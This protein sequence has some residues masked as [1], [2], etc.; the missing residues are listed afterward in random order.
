MAIRVAHG[1]TG[2]LSGAAGFYVNR[3]RDQD[4]RGAAAGRLADSA[5]DR[6]LRRRVAEFNAMLALRDR[7]RQ[8]ERDA[9]NDARDVADRRR[10]GVLDAIGASQAQADDQR[11]DRALEQQGRLRKYDI[12]QTLRRQQ[13][14]NEAY[15]E[16]NEQRFE[17]QQ[18]LDR[19]RGQ[20]DVDQEI[21]EGLRT[22]GL[23]L[24]PFAEREIQKAKDDY[25]RAVSSGQF[26][27]DALDDLRSQ[28]NERLSQLRRI[29]VSPREVPEIGLQERFDRDTLRAPDGSLYQYIPNRG[30]QQLSQPEPVASGID[31]LEELGRIDKLR[32]DYIQSN[33][34]RYE[35]QR[36]GEAFNQGAYDQVVA[37]A[38]Q[39]YPDPG[40][41][42]PEQQDLAPPPSI[43][44]SPST[45]QP[46]AERE[47]LPRERAATPSPGTLSPDE[48]AARR[49]L[50]NM[51]PAQR[52]E[53]LKQFH[54]LT[55]DKTI[56]ELLGDPQMR[57]EYQSLVDAGMRESGNYE[58]FGVEV[59]DEF[60]RE[61]LGI[62]QQ[63]ESFVGMRADDVQDAETRRMV[64]SLPRPKTA[65][66]LQNI[67]GRYFV[68][69]EGVI[70]RAF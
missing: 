3:E 11:Q 33:S 43:Q 70:R 63:R 49:D 37:E 22:G 65:A 40:S 14:Q 36:E 1:L 58:Q 55:R 4:R 46:P 2:A 47:Q 69:P 51:T 60:L 57:T 17:Q 16:R 19:L 21:V 26:S 41:A 39:R 25:T 5:L 54:P 23:E 9:I 68:D 30:W 15:D 66:E 52:V 10:R 44:D 35:P 8:D 38:Q 59:V 20:F 50:M 18:E 34:L 32:S 42:A 56:A 6:D 29:G 67:R 61:E 27:P 31:Q 28:T 24:S 62:H 12:D 13:L 48:S 53:S 7:D 45:I 64:D